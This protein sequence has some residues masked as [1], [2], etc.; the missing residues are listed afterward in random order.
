MG[1]DSDQA[2]RDVATWIL[3]GGIHEVFL[4]GKNML[5]AREELERAGFPKDRLHWFSDPESLGEQLAASVREGDMI[6]LKGSQGMRLEKAVEMVL[7]DPSG[8]RARLCR[9]SD[10]WKRI[11]FLLS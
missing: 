10:E 6:L 8:M 1:A 5:L 2:H 7:L 3:D 9:Q 4:L 11:P